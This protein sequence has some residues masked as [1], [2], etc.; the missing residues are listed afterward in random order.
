MRNY[1]IKAVKTICPG[2]TYHGKIVNVVVENGRIADIFEGN[3][4]DQAFQGFLSSDKEIVD[5][6]GQILSPGFFDLNVN[7]GEPGFEY[8]E[9]L[10]SG[11]KAAF[12]GG[13]T[14]VAVHPNTNPPLS[15]HSEVAFVVHRSKGLAVDIHPIGTV[16]KKRKGEELAELYDMQ[17][18]GAIAFSDGDA[19]LQKAGLMGKALLYS[20][21]I[22]GLIISFPEDTS[23]SDDAQMNEG[24]TSTFLGMKGKPN[25]SESL[26]VS[27]DLA[28]ASY[29]DASIHFTTISTAESVH[30]IRETKANGVK[31]TADVAAHQ[32]VL[33][34]DELQGFD[35]HF[36]VNPP[37]RTHHDARALIEGLKDGTI[38]AVVSQHT[39]H[40]IEFKRV[41]FQI[42]KNGIIGLQT[43]LPLLLE[44][45]LS[46]EQ[47]VEK[48]AI[49]PRKILR[50]EAPRIEK[51]EKTNFVLF[52]PTKEW[53]FKNELNFSKSSNSPYIGKKMRGMVTLTAN[54]GQTF[55]NEYH[56]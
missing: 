26:V 3:L 7:F 38:D 16:S 42:A 14:A 37:L 20:K 39:P 28:L 32:L 9:D 55:R 41:E 13:F 21:G 25:L 43:V 34:E 2:S 24:I 6:T 27:R 52:D 18:A 22:N 45:K 53:V 1:I 46:V 23:V 49:N 12:A 10:I 40:E 31:V 8:K 4:E 48:L 11:S 54:N 35:S 36:K 56:G 47:I 5:G 19:S 17:L 44:A 15:G 33:T 50:L 30:L 29:H 51:G